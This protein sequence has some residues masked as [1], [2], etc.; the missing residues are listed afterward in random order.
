MPTP[1]R[2]S[3]ANYSVYSQLPRPHYMEANS[4][5]HNVS[6]RHIV[7]TRTQPNE[8]AVYIP[9]PQKSERR[10]KLRSHKKPDF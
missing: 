3:V 7:V 4:S 10:P 8:A 6:A 1:C 9:P 2:L 5:I